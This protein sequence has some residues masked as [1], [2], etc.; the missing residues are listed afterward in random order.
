MFE[1]QLENISCKTIGF[2]IKIDTEGMTGD[3]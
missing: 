3:E 2:N 1:V